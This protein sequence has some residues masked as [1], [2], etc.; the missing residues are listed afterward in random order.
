M[1]ESAV[2][3]MTLVGNSRLSGDNKLADLRTWLEI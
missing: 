2:E 3:I 1:F